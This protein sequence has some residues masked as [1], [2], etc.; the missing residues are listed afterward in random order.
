MTDPTAVSFTIP[1]I[2]GGVAPMNPDDFSRQQRAKL[3]RLMNAPSS[4]S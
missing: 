4:I 2:D 3:D 1:S